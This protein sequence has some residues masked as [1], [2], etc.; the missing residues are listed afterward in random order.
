MRSS[1]LLQ[2]RW[3]ASGCGTS[4]VLHH[5][6]TRCSERPP[7]ACFLAS[8]ARSSSTPSDDFRSWS[9]AVCVGRIDVR[10][11]TTSCASSRPRGDHALRVDAPAS[12]HLPSEMW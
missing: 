7:A 5:Q 2:H 4:V 8:R 12:P 1:Q 11:S 6:V 9:A 10:M 3:P